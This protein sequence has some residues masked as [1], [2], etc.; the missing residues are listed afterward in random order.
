MGSINELRERRKEGRKH[1]ERFMSLNCIKT[2]LI[3]QT[4]EWQGEV[5]S[6]E[7]IQN[8]IKNVNVFQ[9]EF[10]EKAI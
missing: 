2:S 10:T 6:Q 9:Y 4:I 1:R 3:A 8:I 5:K 7:E